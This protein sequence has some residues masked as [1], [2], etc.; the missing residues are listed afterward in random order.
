MKIPAVNRLFIGPRLTL[1]FALI[2]LLMLCGD[3]ILLW[4]FRSARLEAERVTGV[5]EELI[6]GVNL[7]AALVSFD[8]QLDKLA[9][10]ED[11]SFLSREAAPLRNVLLDGTERSRNALAE[12]PSETRPDPTFE[13]TI[14]AIESTLV[15]QLAALTALAST[16]D[17]KAVRLRIAKENK[18]LETQTSTLVKNINQQVGKELAQA[19]ANISNVQRRMLLLVPLTGLLTLC[20][21][22]FL[23][24]FITRSI[25]APLSKLVEGSRALA[26]GDFQHQVSISGQDELG[27]LGRVFNDTA[28]QLQTLYRTLRRKE[29]YLAEAQRLTHTGSWAWDVATR[30]VFWSEETYRIFG[31]ESGIPVTSEMFLQRIH[32]E[33]HAGVAVSEAALF[34]GR[35]AEYNYRLLLPY[36][37]IK[38]IRS[39]GHSVK[40]DRGEVVEFVGSAVDITEQRQAQDKLERA[41][42]ELRARTETLRRSE[43]YLA[44]AQKLARSGS[45]AWDVRTNAIIWSR[46]NFRI[47]E[48][49]PDTVQPTWAKI[50]ERVHPEDR[51]PMQERAALESTRTHNIDSEADYRIVLPDGR[52]KHLH[53]IAHPVIDEHGAVVEV[54]GTTMDVTDQWKARTALEKAFGEIKELKEQLHRENIALREEID[55]V[56]MFEEIVGSSDPL[57]R[58]LAQVAKVAPTESTVLILGE[59][60]TG[61]EMI[62]RAIHKRSHRSAQAFIRVNCAAIPPALI[63]SELFGHEKGAFTGAIQRRLGRFELADGGTIFLDEIG[64]FPA[65][66][67]SVLLRVL[68]ER[69]FERVGGTQPI[70]VDVRIL[71]ATNRDLRAAVAAG[72]FRADLFYRLN[73]FPIKLPS[74]RERA[75]DIP[76]LVEYLIDRY[77][78]KAGKKISQI[79]KRTLDIFQSYDWPGNIRELQNVVERAVV[80]CEGQTFFVDETWLKRDDRCLKRYETHLKGDGTWLKRDETWLKRDDRLL[81]RYETQPKG[82]GR[83]LKRDE[84]RLKRDDAS[85]RSDEAGQR[86]D[87]TEPKGNLVSELERPTELEPPSGGAI[88]SDEAREG[89][90]WNIPGGR[91]LARLLPEEEKEIIEAALAGSRGRIS[92][93]KGAAAKLGIPRQTLESKIASL[94]IDKH[95]FKSA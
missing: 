82:D 13:P 87:E 8:D 38:Y 43:G 44:E 40:N 69:E 74:L 88:E 45:W 62:A 16:G 84:T 90:S 21:A 75:D 63:A 36:N 50:L 54:V 86:V 30:Q 47:Y 48:Y 73:V 2:V 59:T 49:D 20:L 83:L 81:K 5:S 71:S 29:A 51:S 10:T 32:P 66:T 46:E 68:Q 33:D 12:L 3:G 18:P 19:I 85:L 65:E 6:A 72:T 26:R 91:G 52:I 34:A 22:G 76:L 70:S 15:P 77:A 56:S 37:S 42:H 78:K 89:N 27:E 79:D 95:K 28:V 53:S 57:R 41:L 9:Q 94:G 1:C 7:Q 93:P 25:T 4:Q 58:V 80:L 35:D 61:K 17:W 31:F 64:E 23:G 92:G 24:V 14:E 55:K 67:Q 39:L 11:A 60:G